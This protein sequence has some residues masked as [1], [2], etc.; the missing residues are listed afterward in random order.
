MRRRAAAVTGLAI[1]LGTAGPGLGQAAKPGAVVNGEAIPWEEVEAT[2]GQRPP[3]IAPLTAAQKRQLQMDVL[4]G[5]IDELLVRQFLRQNGPKID[6]AEIERKMAGL[7]ASLR[8]QGKTIA[9]FCKENHQ[10]EAQVRTSLETLLALDGYLRQQA[11]QA[12]L[13]AYYEQNK[14]YFHKVTVRASHIVFRL[15]PDAPPA[16]REQAK[17][18]LLELRQQIAA[19]TLKFADAARQHSQCPTAP[20]GGDLGTFPRKWWDL[21]E[22]IVAAAFALKPG[23]VSGVVETD[24]GVHLV[25]TTERTPGTPVTYE[26]CQEDVKDCYGAELRQSLVVRLRREAKVTITLP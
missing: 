7:A 21:D 8:E 20:R 23:E 10:T 16:E 13:K 26:Q 14:D 19:G 1:L 5:L 12:D 17:Q 22:R 2:L 18:R 9:D 24:F 3:A 6:P 25:Q 4:N 11:S 15:P